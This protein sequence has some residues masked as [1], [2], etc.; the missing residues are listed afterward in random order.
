MPE[1]TKMRIGYGLGG[2]FCTVSKAMEQMRQLVV[3]GYDVTPIM[4]ENTQRTETRYG[5]AQSFIDQAE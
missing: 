1:N 2:S 4:S 5:T 3:Q